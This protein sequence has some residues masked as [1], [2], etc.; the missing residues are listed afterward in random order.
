M[1]QVRIGA[2]MAVGVLLCL[3]LAAVS[4]AFEDRT[5]RVHAL[6][7]AR[8]IPAPGV[9][10]EDATLV[11]RD[12]IIEAVGK[13]EPPADARLWDLH[14]LTVY[15]GL[16]EPFYDLDG[17]SK[18]K[19]DDDAKESSPEVGVR[20]QNAR[21]RAENR[22]V[23][24]K[25]LSDK[26]RKALRDLGFTTVHLVNTKGAF[27]GQSALVDL[28]DGDVAE[29]VVRADV[30]QI[31]RFEHASWSDKKP[32]YPS[33][34]MGAVALVRQTFLDAGWAMEASARYAS[35]SGGFEQPRSNLS[36]DALAA[37]LDQDHPMPVWL[38]TEDVL[39]SLRCAGLLRGVHPLS[40]TRSDWTSRDRRIRASSGR[41]R[42][43]WGS[44]SPAPFV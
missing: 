31:V 12:G 14:G 30:A 33:S 36:W 11:L 1:R 27:C 44:S 8:V 20:H 28:Y 38:V 41:Q 23:E 32:I 35:R 16:I 18:G 22:V 25:M 26:E 7:G 3:C 13:V 9:V 10:L 43:R 21:V 15:A 19:K 42:F 39:G 37:T 40:D 34:L 29:Q 6:V 2:A 24:S 17:D 4:S 5:P